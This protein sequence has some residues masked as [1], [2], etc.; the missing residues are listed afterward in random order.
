MKTL[1]SVILGIFF[2]TY[3]LLSLLAIV[4]KWMTEEQKHNDKERWL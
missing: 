4:A 1:L 2:F 3:V